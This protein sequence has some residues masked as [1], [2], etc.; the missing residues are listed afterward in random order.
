MQDLR[1]SNKLRRRQQ[2]LQA[3]RDLI[4]ADGIGALSMR[5]LAHRARV[6]VP[7]VYALVGGR[8]DVIAALLAE[9]AHRFDDGMGAVTT[10]G[11]FRVTDVIELLTGIVDHERELVR[12]L[13]ASGIL[14]SAGSERFLLLDRVRH[15]LARAFSEAVARGELAPGT[16]PDVAATVMVRLG[17]GALLDWVVQRGGP[18]DL[19]ADL[20]RSGSV[21]IAAFS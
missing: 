1:T 15:E 19:R 4:T 3:A 5:A 17:L 9:G 6:S 16:D 20:L 10:L 18:D 21:V 2:I 13:L 7:T 8:D 11:L 12:G 14:T